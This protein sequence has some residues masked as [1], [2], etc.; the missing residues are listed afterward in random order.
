MSE[1]TRADFNRR[2]AEAGGQPGNAIHDLW[3]SRDP[4][5]WAR[6]PY[7]HLRLGELANSLGQSMFAHDILQE[8]LGFFPDGLELKK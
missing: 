7:F 5:A 4:A 6:D 3:R 1:Q 8:G 2:L